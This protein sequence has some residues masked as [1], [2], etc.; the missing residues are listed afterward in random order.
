MRKFDD[1]GRNDLLGF[2]VFYRFSTELSMTF[3]SGLSE[4]KLNNADVVEWQTQQTQN[5]ISIFSGFE[6]STI[7]L[8]SQTA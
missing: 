5:P 1:C 4:E 6:L 2:L 7:C 8:I 3:E